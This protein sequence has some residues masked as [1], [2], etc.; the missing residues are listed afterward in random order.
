[1]QF[2]QNILYSFQ[3]EEFWKIIANSTVEWTKPFTK[4]MECDMVEGN[5]KWFSDGTLNASGKTSQRVKS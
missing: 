5:F 3:P 1:M 4:V 2:F